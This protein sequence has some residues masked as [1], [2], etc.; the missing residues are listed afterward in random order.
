MFDDQKHAEATGERDAYRDE[1][2]HNERYRR[3]ADPRRGLERRVGH[4]RWR[5]ASNWAQWETCSAAHATLWAQWVPLGR[6]RQPTLSRVAPRL[7]H[8]LAASPATRLHGAIVGGRR[9]VFLATVGPHIA[10]GTSS[11][12]AERNWARDHHPV[13]AHVQVEG[14]LGAGVWP[15][16]GAHLAPTLR[17][18]RHRLSIQSRGLLGERPR[19]V[20]PQA[21]AWRECGRFTRW[22]NVDWLE[23]VAG[24]PR[25]VPVGFHREHFRRNGGARRACFGVLVCGARGRGPIVSL[26][27]R[28]LV[29]IRV[30]VSIGRQD[31]RHRARR[32]GQVWPESRQRCSLGASRVV[33]QVVVVR[34]T[35]RLMTVSHLVRVGFVV[36]GRTIKLRSGGRAAFANCVGLFSSVLFGRIHRSRLTRYCLLSSLLRLQLDAGWQLLSWLPTCGSNFLPPVM[37]LIWRWGSMCGAVD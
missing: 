4:W 19:L 37:V 29:R 23:R 22:T 9:H 34:C 15:A 24:Q 13:G 26:W 36:A 30:S 35:G 32:A 21:W 16:G 31:G 27:A 7:R 2:H 6:A 1:H 12:L 8:V 14:G 28:C 11:V 33:V 20:W 3:V 18:R 17:R 5:G 10:T 25:L